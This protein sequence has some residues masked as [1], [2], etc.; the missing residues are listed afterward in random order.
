MIVRSKQS[1]RGGSLRSGFTLLELI[2]SVA[3]LLIILLALVHAFDRGATAWENG[4][5]MAEQNLAGRVVVDYMT[6]E[7]S[8]AVAKPKYPASFG[9]NSIEFHMLNSP[10][11][12]PGYYRAQR[13]R[14][15]VDADGTLI[16]EATQLNT[17]GNADD[18]ITTTNKLCDGVEILRFDSS[19]G[20]S[21]ST[22]PD[23]VDIYLEI[24]KRGRR[25]RL[26]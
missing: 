13:I 9:G 5:R 2:V 24:R 16:R 23:H 22:L 1:V 4:T 12:R 19:S 18:N 20:G 6:L 11:Q 7:L 15:A 3:V 21:A 25:A 10:D 26:Y 17:S 14:Y 8:Q